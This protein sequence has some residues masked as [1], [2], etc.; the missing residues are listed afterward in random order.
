MGKLMNGPGVT[1]LHIW[2]SPST[3]HLGI[4]VFILALNI[5]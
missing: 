3:S 5:A 1:G 2:P 4:R